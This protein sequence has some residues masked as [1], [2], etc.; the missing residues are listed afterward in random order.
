[1]STTRT[2]NRRTA[3]AAIADRVPFRNSG[4]TFHGRPVG[5]EYGYGLGMIG[6][7]PSDHVETLRAA[8]RSGAVDFIVW[9]YGTPIAWTG[10][11]GTVIPDE[12]YSP[13]TSGHQTIA[14]VALSLSA[15]DPYIA[16]SR[17]QQR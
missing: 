1:M 15:D 10:S 11:G 16:R 9:S 17:S 8:L 13:T 7:L 12:R 5:E 4:G 14:R 3:A 2:V 6:R